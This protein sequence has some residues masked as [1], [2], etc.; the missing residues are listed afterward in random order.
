MIGTQYVAHEAT[1]DGHVL[2][3]ATDIQFAINPVLY[4]KL[5]Y[6]PD[7][8]FV[9]LAMGGVAYSGL[10]VNPSLE[11]GSLGE[12]IALAKSKPGQ[13]YYGSAGIGSIH[14]MGMELIKELANIDIVHV[15]YRGGTPALLDLVAGQ[16]QI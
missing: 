8:D 16:V 1:P 13:L 5:T 15:P 14:H 9:P 6:S 3:L 4:R 7:E 10:V 2:L 11:V 12:L